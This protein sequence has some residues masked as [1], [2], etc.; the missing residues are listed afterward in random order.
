MHFFAAKIEIYG[1]QRSDFTVSTSNKFLSL[2][3][4]CMLTKEK[5]C[6][7]KVL[8]LGSLKFLEKKFQYIERMTL[9]IQLFRIYS[10]YSVLPICVNYLY[11]CVNLFRIYS[12]LPICVN[13]PLEIF[14]REN[15]YMNV[16]SSVNL[17]IFKIF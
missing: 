16:C 17:L 4:H 14:S 15:E 6:S 12:V 9:I 10:M 13:L 3:V 5:T 11:I 8:K 2:L 1:D 7:I